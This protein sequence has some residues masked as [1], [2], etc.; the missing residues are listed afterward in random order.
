MSNNKKFVRA[1]LY[2]PSDRAMINHSLALHHGLSLMPSNFVCELCWQCKG[3][4]R[5]RLWDEDCQSCGATGLTQ[6]GGVAP[7]T[8][9]M[10]RQV[11]VAASRSL[12]LDFEVVVR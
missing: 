1:P 9:S 11:L 6:A 5:R 7:A 8:D 10:R 12:L 2:M 3:E 4:C